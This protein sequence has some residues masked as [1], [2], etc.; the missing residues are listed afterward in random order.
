MLYACIHTCTHSF[1][2]IYI[3]KFKYAMK[4]ASKG[5]DAIFYAFLCLRYLVP[6]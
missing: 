4:L 3:K 6:G 2:C 1:W 5:S